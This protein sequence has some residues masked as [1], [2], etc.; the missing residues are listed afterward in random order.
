[1]LDFLLRNQDNLIIGFFFLLVGFPVG[2]LYS[3]LLGKQEVLP[4]AT[5]RVGTIVEVPVSPTTYS[6]RRNAPSGSDS[7]SMMLGQ[8]VVV[9]L[10][11][12]FVYWHEQVLLAAAAAVCF[13]IGLFVGATLYAHKIDAI[14]RNG[15][16]A[17]L[18]LTFCVAVLSFVLIDSALRP[19]YAPPEFGSY[20]DVLRREKIGVFLRWVG[21]KNLTW[22]VTHVAG[23]FLLLYVQVRLVLSLV[24]YLAMLRLATSAC[25]A[26]TQWFAVSTRK[27]GNPTKNCVILVSMS[28]AS[29]LLVNGYA[30]VWYQ[31]L[32]QT[33]QTL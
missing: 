6:R 31:Q 14:D 33:A 11:F 18:L 8:V 15:W 7:D 25:G 13:S 22:L 20:Q 21:L 23:V 3:R 2:Q 16:S 28:I 32:F 5:V 17:Y 24:H 1:M 26:I 9:L 27:Y 12:G 10:C 19:I 30:F 29:F 4:A